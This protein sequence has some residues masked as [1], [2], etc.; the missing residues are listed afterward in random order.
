MDNEGYMSHQEVENIARIH[1]GYPGKL[2]FGSKSRYRD[3]YPDH[4]VAFNSNLCT[5][6]YGKIWF[7]DI[8]IT[9][10]TDKLE[11][12]ADELKISIYVLYEMDARFEYEDDPQF[13]NAIYIAGA[14][15]GN[16]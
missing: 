9:I 6:E 11:K 14:Q 13:D 1:L 16:A 10:D 5:K 3:R 2:L 12:L 7:G 8:D 15:Y 4:K